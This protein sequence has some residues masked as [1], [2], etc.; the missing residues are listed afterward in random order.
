MYSVIDQLI[1]L[2]QINHAYAISLARQLEPEFPGLS[3]DVAAWPIIKPTVDICPECGG[4]G[5]LVYHDD[6]G[7]TEC[8][9]CNGRG[10]VRIKEE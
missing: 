6:S 4:D 7:I 10:S 9:M 8:P 2:H 3:D 5:Y 1:A